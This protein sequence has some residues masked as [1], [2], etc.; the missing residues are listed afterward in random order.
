MGSLQAMTSRVQTEL[1][2]YFMEGVNGVMNEIWEDLY[3]YGDFVG[4]K[5]AVDEGEGDY[6]LKL[7]DRL[8]EWKPVEGGVSGGERSTACLALRVAFAMVLAP[9]LRWIV[10][11]EPTHNLDT[12][13]VEELAKVLRERLPGIVK[14]VLLITHN[15]RLE[16]AVSG[17]LYRF[18]RDKA[19]GEPTRYEMVALGI[20]EAD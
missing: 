19:K 2:K 8:G 15:E 4:I 9:S 3:P 17:Y 1:R 13:G 7:R 16:E 18:Y 6:V 5:L 14:Q 10:F 11:D 20:H 12:R